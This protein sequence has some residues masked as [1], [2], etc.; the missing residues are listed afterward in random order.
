MTL[1]VRQY[2]FIA[3]FLTGLL[4]MICH[5]DV[6]A[7]YPPSVRVFPNPGE[8]SLTV[9]WNGVAYE[10]TGIIFEGYNIYITEA[11][12]PA[13][14]NYVIGYDVEDFLKHVRLNKN[15]NWVI[16]D[17]PF[18]RQQI[19]AIYCLTN[20]TAYSMKDWYNFRDS[21]FYF[22][23]FSNN[24]FWLTDTSIIHKVYPTMPYPTS[25]DPAFA[26]NWEVTPDGFLRYFEYEY[27]LKNLEPLTEYII[28]IRRLRVKSYY[29]IDFTSINGSPISG[30]TDEHTGIAD[31]NPI[32]MVPSEFVVHQNFPNPFNPSTNITFDLPYRENVTVT[33]YN[34]LGQA[35]SEIDLGEKAAGSHL[36]SWD[37][38][39]D[40]GRDVAG[41]VY[42]YK[43]K[44]GE[45][46]DTRKMV[47]LR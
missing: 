45:M 17:W 5:S 16:N 37:S 8:T 46:T 1:K 36:V 31:N 13:S 41:G 6:L 35:I 2:Y 47:L 4:L 28:D 23:A 25:L 7:Q 33:I 40:S 3:V 19:L 24:I 11:S 44:A 32:S 39:D 22:T 43:V 12:N 30:T 42:F 15:H 26:N 9:R 27:T 10:T 34:I 20:P 29:R 18:T 14:F 38:K 21:Q